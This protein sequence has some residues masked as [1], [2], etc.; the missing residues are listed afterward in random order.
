MNVNI[1]KKYFIFIII[2][3]WFLFSIIF[4]KKFIS[5]TMIF[6]F[7]FLTYFCFTKKKKNIFK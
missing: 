3:K 2:F 7:N 6:I 5:L 4:T 1:Y